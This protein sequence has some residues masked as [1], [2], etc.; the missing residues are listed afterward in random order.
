MVLGIVD[1]R[2][3]TA[4]TLM[5][6]VTVIFICLAV[7]LSG[8][9]HDQKI[10]PYLDKSVPFVGTD[11]PRLEGADGSG[12]LIAVIDTGVDY[13]HPDMLGWQGDGKVVGGYNLLWSEET[14]FDTDGHGTQVA[15]VASADGLLQGVAPK[16]KIL[17][18]KVSEKGDN[19]SSD[20][21][22][23]AVTRAVE[24]G[25]DIINISMGITQP[26]A[27]IE[28]AI[29]EAL[30]RGVLVVVAAGNEGPAASSIGSPGR[31]SGS[32]TVGATYNNLTSSMVATLDVND[33]FSYTVVPMI[34]TESLTDPI[35]APLIP[36]G[37]AKASDFEGID[38]REAIAVAQRGSDIEDELLYFSLKEKH[39]ADAGAAALIVYNN[40]D[41]IFLG[42]LIHAFIEPGYEPRIPVVSMDREEGLEL[43]K[44]VDNGTA[45]DASLHLFH[46][47]DYVAHFSSRGPVSSFYIK[48]DL[49]APGAYI[50]TTHAGSM[51]NLTSGTSYAAPH[52]SG[53]AALLLQK[54]P[55]LDRHEL[56][57]IIMTT[58]DP[59]LDVYGKSLPIHEAGSGRL[60]ISRAYEADVAI[61]PP[62]FVAIISEQSQAA[63]QRL[64]VR[65]VV[66]DGQHHI[67]NRDEVSVFFTGPDF[68]GFE[69][70]LDGNF[71][72]VKMS[73]LNGTASGMNSTPNDGVD[74][75][76]GQ[77]EGRITVTFGG[78]DYIVPFLLHYTRGTVD[79][80]ATYETKGA[81]NGNDDAVGKYL[82]FDISHPDGWEFAKIDVIDSMTEETVTIT[83]TPDNAAAGV[84]LE[85][86]K[87]GTYW[88]DAKI[89]ADGESYDAY[90]VVDVGFDSSDENSS[91]VFD[92]LWLERSSEPQKT[93]ALSESLPVRQIILV[94]VVA[95]VVGAVGA[96][97]KLGN[98]HCSDGDTNDHFNEARDHDDHFHNGSGILHPDDAVF[99]DAVSDAASCDNAASA[100]D[101]F[102]YTHK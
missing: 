2:R 78:S 88:I 41:G 36:A 58:A 13:Q 24:D 65:P 45:S 85:V 28:A 64:E 67:L 101:R 89:T 3:P 48:P 57:S 40:V 12:V 6:S 93:F 32:I 8:T 72:L 34:G 74:A 17:A 54:N 5:A 1:W 75:A 7:V 81:A 55:D 73:I 70:E 97:L 94:V 33:S 87:D 31:S 79:A 77:Y 91:D 11:V 44:L 82:T 4:R 83:A 100:R 30:A 59:V 37:Y 92:A 35:R 90:D 95:V 53:A 18:Y 71:V 42:E 22:A 26:N 39:A 27:V 61:L 86:Q 46:N 99:D 51:Y 23:Q 43:L 21:I 69:H 38:V 50:N 52:V 96:A 16:S 98:R 29:N 68:I 63:Q 62:S 25:A 80:A 10:E 15:G 102:D 66:N 20:L 47:P 84:I 76:Y 49:V 60:N 9:V 14:P 56:K 19:V